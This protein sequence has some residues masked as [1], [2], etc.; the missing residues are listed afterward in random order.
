MVA[1]RRPFAGESSAALLYAIVHRAPEPFGGSRRRFLRVVERALA[2]ALAKSPARSHR[3]VG[4]F[5]AELAA[6][7]AGSTAPPARRP[8][9]RRTIWAS[10]GL[11]AARWSRLVARFRR[12]PTPGARGGA[13]P[14][15]PTSS[16][17]SH[18]P[19]AARLSPRHPE[20]AMALYEQS[21]ATAR[22]A[23]ALCRPRRGSTLALRRAAATRAAERA[24]ESGELAVASD[25]QPRPGPAGLGHRLAVQGRPEEALRHLD[26]A[27]ASTP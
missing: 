12:S 15:A 1:G 23:P 9:M 10:R 17:R 8:R 16:A 13:R 20:R 19:A 6:A 25:P 11:T 18:G 5:V 3:G 4:D 2:R 7:R 21:W 22:H 27:V 26:E 24:R 14:A